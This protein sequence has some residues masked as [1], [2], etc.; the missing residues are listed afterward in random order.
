MR[1]LLRA[2]VVVIAVVTAAPAAS[3]APRP[4][5]SCTNVSGTVAA[6]AIPIIGPTGLV[7]FNVIVTATGDLS[8]AASASLSIERALPGGTLHLTGTHNYSASPYG[9][10]TVADRVVA[11]PS[12]R[13]HNTSQVISGGS[14]FLVSRG[15]IDYATGA[16]TLEY[17]GR[18]CSG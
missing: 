7:G 2:C 8:G 5:T 6:F 13:V 14:G 4:S 10:L 11:T 15:T 16:L 9:A 1:I 3:A 17:H 18:I 12:G